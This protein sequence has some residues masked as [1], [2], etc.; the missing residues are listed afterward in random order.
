MAL[1]TCLPETHVWG[2]APGCSFPYRITMGYGVREGV[3]PLMQTA[4]HRAGFPTSILNRQALLD[5]STEGQGY[6]AELG[7]AVVLA[8]E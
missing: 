8:A 4:S 2:M 1:P 6:M 7:R 3:Q 5:G